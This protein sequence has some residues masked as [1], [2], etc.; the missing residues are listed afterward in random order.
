MD[1]TA[2]AGGMEF[3]S[4]ELWPKPSPACQ[5]RCGK[6]VR[7]PSG[8]G[9]APRRR[10]SIAAREGGSGPAE[11]MP[12]PAEMVPRRR[13]HR[14]RQANVRKGWNELDPENETVG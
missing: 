4:C 8:N 7:P 1:R 6:S 2:K 11:M 13:G 9:G 5:I 10:G 3:T 12:R 14:V